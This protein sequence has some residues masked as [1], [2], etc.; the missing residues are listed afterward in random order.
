MRYS[1]PAPVWTAHRWRGGLRCGLTGEEFR[2]AH[3]V[4]PWRH[5]VSIDLNRSWVS[6]AAM[7]TYSRGRV[8]WNT[9]SMA[10]RVDFHNGWE[11]AA[12]GTRWRHRPSRLRAVQMGIRL[13][14]G[15]TLGL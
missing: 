11:G 9:V 13:C 6:L 3:P 12:G 1:V 7:N 15:G 14:V 10:A 5:V 8:H 4:I 2:E